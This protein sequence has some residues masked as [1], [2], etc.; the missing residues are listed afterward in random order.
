MSYLVPISTQVPMKLAALMAGRGLSIF[1]A[2][3]QTKL[4]VQQLLDSQT[5]M[6]RYVHSSLSSKQINKAYIE[7][8]YETSSLD[9][10]SLAFQFLTLSYR[11][12]SMFSNYETVKVIILTG[13]D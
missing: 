9:S 2:V 13:I 6:N 11:P 7:R 4:H 12:K 10:R 3:L 8:T 5:N 1:D